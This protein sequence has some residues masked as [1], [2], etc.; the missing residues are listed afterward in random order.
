MKKYSVF[1]F[2][3]IDK[4]LSNEEVETLREFY[5]YYHKKVWC[6]RKAFKHFKHSPFLVLFW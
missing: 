1:E 5:N 3:H 6:Y 2:N 4:R